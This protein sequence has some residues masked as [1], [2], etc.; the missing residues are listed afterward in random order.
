[1]KRRVYAVLVFV[2][3]SSGALLADDQKPARV[4]VDEQLLMVTAQ[5][6]RPLVMRTLSDG[7]AH[8]VLDER[9]EH[10]LVARVNEAGELELTCT[11]DHELAAALLRNQPESIM[12]L[13]GNRG[14]QRH[15]AERE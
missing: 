1:M 10:K 11:D 7:G 13:R 8:V 5:P 2:F 15:R 14:A 3:L 4:V 6:E 9:F 12:R